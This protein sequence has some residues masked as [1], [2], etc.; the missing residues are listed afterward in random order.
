MKI[1]GSLIRSGDRVID[2]GGNRG[3]YAYR[4]WRLGARIEVFEPNPT[5][6]R[7][8]QAWA[9]GKPRVSVHSVAL[10]NCS[11]SANLHIP[12]DDSGVEHDSSASIEHD[13]FAHARDQLVELRTLDSYGFD[14]VSLIKIDVEGHEYKVIEG[15][16]GTLASSM[17]AV[18]IEIEQRHSGRPISEVF[19]KILRLGY[20]GFFF[21]LNGLTAIED[22]DAAR[23]Q[24]MENFGG[25]RG[26][27]INNFVFL[28]QRRLANGEYGAVVDGRSMK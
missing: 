19:D 21:S 5:C 2:V 27:Y 12:V 28:H 24:S 25:M 3:L 6:L 15:A 18:L 9:A 23:D 13:G 8:L 14:K 10:S 17:P 22:F 16:L 11:G 26:R 4:C 7:V 20:Q 1:L